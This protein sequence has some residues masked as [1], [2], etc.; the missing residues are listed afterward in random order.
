MSYNVGEYYVLAFFVALSTFSGVLSLPNFVYIFCMLFFIGWSLYK[1]D[2]EFDF[3]SISI[4]VFLIVCAFSLLLNN[5]PSYFRPWERLVFYLLVLITFTPLLNSYSIVEERL[6]LTECLFMMAIGFT[7]ASF[8][9]YFLGINFFNPSEYDVDMSVAGHFS[10]FFNHSMILGAVGAVAFIFSFSKMLIKEERN[11]KIIWLV[12]TSMCFVATLLSASRGAA[13]A[14]VIGAIAVLYQ[15]SKMR[16][17]N[18]AK[19]I[20]IIIILCILLFP[21]LAIIM[22]GILEKNAA[23]MSEGGMFSSRGNQYFARFMEIKEHFYTGV[24]FACIDPKYDY[25]DTKTGQIEPG[26]SWLA[27]FSMTGVFGFVLFLIIYLKSLYTAI[28]KIKDES[29]SLL[30]C[31]LLVFFG[32]HFIVEAYVMA[33]GNF[34]CGLYWLVAGNVLIYPKYHSLDEQEVV[35][36]FQKTSV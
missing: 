8:F 4:F 18:F 10:G 16:K 32:I 21:V 31:G 20:G 14:A 17:K 11:D 13:G 3:G 15:M 27:V 9:G 19:Y 34:L 12:I 7:V 33:P 28:T 23:N 36:E 6:K 29:L 25:A 5:P 30:S 35:D 1:S 26:S 2:F 22:A 24:G